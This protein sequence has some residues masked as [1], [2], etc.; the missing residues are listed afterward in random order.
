[1]S[2][3]VIIAAAGKGERAGFKRNK[4]LERI[5]GKPVILLTAEV[6]DNLTGI[7]EDAISAEYKDGVLSVNMTKKEKVSVEGR[8]LE[9][10]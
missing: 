8:R 7:D 5:N 9:I 4:L 3:S 10:K 1:M 6:F 2:Y